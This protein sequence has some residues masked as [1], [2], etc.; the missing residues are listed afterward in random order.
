[1]KEIKAICETYKKVDFS[2]QKAVLATVVRVRGSSYRSPGARMLITD[3][4]RWT[5]S[6]SGGCLEGDALRKARK[7]MA[8]KQ[9]ITVTYDTRDDDNSIFKINLGCN[10][11]I[12]V[13]FEVIDP[14]DEYNPIFLFERILHENEV[15][16]LATVFSGKP[17]VLGKKILLQKSL[18]NPQ[19]FNHQGFSKMIEKDL[20]KSME[21]KRSI[22]EKYEIGGEACE[23]F[24]ELIQPP[25][26]LMIFGGGFDARPL[27][28]MGKK[29]GWSV[30]VTDECVAHIAPLFFPDADNLS[31]C[32]R[33]FIDRDFQISSNT[34]CV[35]MSHNYEYDRD[36]LKKILPSETPYIG[37]LGPR[38]RFDKILM[39]FADQNIELSE[40]DWE[41]IH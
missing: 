37:I 11:V 17:E 3:D 2:K 7:V 33:E 30:T 24:I 4:G 15:A 8:D 19:N 28:E 20:W 32:N 38:K 34:A 29:L 36:V 35:L 25:I 10:G 18:F 16:S 27:S 6:I 39:D 22:A 12:D 9:A 13:L 23:V 31:L 40:K 41:R 5:G 26:Q 21:N 1:M 14:A